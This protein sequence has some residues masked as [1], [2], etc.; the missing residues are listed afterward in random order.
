MEGV[1]S[2]PRKPRSDAS[3][4][5]QAKAEKTTKK[6]KEEKRKKEQEGLKS[7]SAEAA[8]GMG[9]FGQGD[10]AFELGSG[11]L[12]K[13]DPFV[14]P[15]PFIKPE[16]VVKAELMYDAM[17]YERS[18]EPMVGRFAGVAAGEA[19]AIPMREDEDME[20]VSPYPPVKEYRAGLTM[21]GEGRM[22][23][24]AEPVEM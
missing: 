12:V 8:Q 4:A 17:E 9:R 24:K 2:T 19:E 1:P 15:E 10:D 22:S 20:Y 5:R 6:E 23:V 21:S 3:R 18:E 13:S 14:R 7:E 11:E 16:P